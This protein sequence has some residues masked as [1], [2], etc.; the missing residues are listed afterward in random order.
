MPGLRYQGWTF[1][2]KV[3]FVSAAVV[4]LLLVFLDVVTL[5]AF[6]PEMDLPTM[7]LIALLV[8]NMVGFAMAGHLAKLSGAR[9][10]FWI[11]T[12]PLSETTVLDAV[13]GYF[14]ER[15][16]RARSVGEK[17]AYTDSFSDVFR[18]KGTKLEV[19]L[20][21]V[22]FPGKGVSI[23]VG[24]EG[25]ADEEPLMA[26]LDEFDA[27]IEKDLLEGLPQKERLEEE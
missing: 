15:K 27:Y 6:A 7:V 11:R 13:I 1:G 17:H 5:G 26:F 12:Y 23:H 20:R 25:K 19:R 14:S 18:C 4:I 9:H 2:G 21:P 8:L 10:G 3:E 24:P 16:A 22:S